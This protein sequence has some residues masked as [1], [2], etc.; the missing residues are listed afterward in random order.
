M[1]NYLL[2]F[3]LL[4]ISYSQLN[5]ITPQ[6]INEVGKRAYIYAYPLVTTIVT[7]QIMAKKNPTNK[8]LHV[9]T[10][11]DDKYTD[12][13]RPNVDTLYSMA[14]LDLSKSPVILS[15]P[16]THGRYYLIE[17]M[18]AWT[19]VFAS[20][21]KRTTGTKAKE[22]AIV[23]PRWKGYISKKYKKIQS[24]TNIAWIVGRT[25]TNGIQDYNSVHT[26]QDGYQ[27]SL[28]LPSNIPLKEEIID[29]TKSPKDY[30][31]SMNAKTFFT[32]FA[33][34]LKDNPPALSNK[35]ILK[36]LKRIGIEVG[37]KFDIDKLSQEIIKG[38]DESITNAQKEILQKAKKFGQK[39]NGWQIFKN[40]GTYGNDY[41]TRA[42]VAMLGI[43]ANLPEDA[44]YPMTFEDIE[45]NR[46][47]G[48]NKYIIH[49]EKNT[50]PPT[51]AFWSMTMYNK[52]SYLIPNKI[53]RY[54]LGDRDNLKFNKDGSLDI[55]IQNEMPEE[56][57]ISNW[58]PAPL[59]DFNLT[60]R[61]YWP[62]N[63]VLNGLW[64]PP[65]I[66]KLS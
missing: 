10:F 49:F 34:Q 61:I 6:E 44:L 54:S 15:V 60:L 23:G 53:N 37:K 63:S 11:P 31:N 35:T 7:K 42:T 65:G 39:I 28:L 64:N 13:V 58:L 21:G 19:N 46:L 32:F 59:D 20:I 62:R 18:D 45:G 50:L 2:F 16:D 5:S 41:L 51:K 12:I 36:Q 40:I 3:I 38:L 66:V 57:L 9:R 48:K 52:D 27:L 47:T 14:W 30:V 4:S 25:Q 55:F 33:E 8:F 22:F 26:I 17:I 43:A 24:P 1:R 29:T 56:K